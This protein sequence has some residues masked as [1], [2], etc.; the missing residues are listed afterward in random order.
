MKVLITD[1]EPLARQRLERMLLQLGDF[2][3]AQVSH[4]L[5][6]V[7]YCQKNA[8]ELVFMDI[9]MPGMDGLEAAYHLT[10][11]E[12]P[13][14]V[15]FVTAYD[16]YA[17][18]AF[19][20][21]AVDYLLKPVKQEDIESAL[22]KASR[23]NRTQVQQLMEESKQ[24]QRQHISTRLRGEVHLIPVK[25]IFYFQADQKYVNVRHVNG[26]AL[27]E[28][29]L[30]QLEQE[31]DQTFIRIHRNALVNKHCISGLV[32]DSAGHLLIQLKSDDTQLEVSRRHA[33]EVRK[34][35]KSL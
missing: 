5:D 28:E 19:S 14:A 6:A 30:K 32:K 31:F 9:R 12:T 22:S 17:L 16:D 4:G 21:S 1:D 13:P 11:M 27:I 8:V 29:P 26:E 20:V 7:N 15:V 25:D 2:D 23:L 33:A 18:Q 34:L 35:I 24:P 10:Q 3:I